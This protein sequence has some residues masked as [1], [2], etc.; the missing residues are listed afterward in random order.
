MGLITLLLCIS[1]QFTSGPLD[2][3]QFSED[4]FENIDLCGFLLLKGNLRV[5][6]RWS[7][8]KAYIAGFKFRTSISIVL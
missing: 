5:E 7:L 4:H 3:P 1:L 2:I 6:E 8:S